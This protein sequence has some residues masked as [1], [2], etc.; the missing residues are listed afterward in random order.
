MF[1]GAG[2]PR[3][4]LSDATLVVEG[5]REQQLRFPL[6]LETSLVEGL[7]KLQGRCAPVLSLDEGLAEAHELGRR[8]GEAFARR[9][10]ALDAA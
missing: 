4:G 3:S 2:E 6:V 5:D 7:R 1:G 9:A 8:D 10:L